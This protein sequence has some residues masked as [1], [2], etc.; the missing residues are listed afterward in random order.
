MTLII[1]EVNDE[2]KI[3]SLWLTNAEK[4]NPELR[5]G[6]QATYTKYHALKYMVAVF[7]SGSETLYENT[8]D[9]LKYNKRRSAEKEI[10]QEKQSLQ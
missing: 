1:I 6:L 7:L 5:T 9:L 4:N 10:Q 3:V 2:K 8:L